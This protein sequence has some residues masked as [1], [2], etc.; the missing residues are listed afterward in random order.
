MP[1]LRIA[2]CA[3]AFGT[4][5]ERNGTALEHQVRIQGGITASILLFVPSPSHGLISLVPWE[6]TASVAD[7]ETAAVNS[8]RILSLEVCLLPQMLPA[9]S[10]RTAMGQFRNKNEA[11]V[12]RGSSA[13]SPE[14]VELYGRTN[15]SLQ[16][17]LVD[18]LALADVD[19][20]PGATFKTR[21]E[22]ACRVLQRG[23]LGEGQLD[24]AL[25]G[26]TGADEAC[27]LPHRDP[28]H[29][30]RRLSPFHRLDHVGV[31]RPDEA[32]D[33]GERLA[34]PIA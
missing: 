27:V 5:A 17:L 2:G 19:G 14:P 7:F 34:P 6:P 1:M 15:K 18:R 16:R 4:F 26:L 28:Q 12:R 13:A 31:G 10:F 22:Q 30:V 33:P 11:G 20:A 9:T 3:G 21:V 23:A 25:V 29:S 32:A 8:P 24:V